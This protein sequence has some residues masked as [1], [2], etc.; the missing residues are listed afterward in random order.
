MLLLVQDTKFETNQNALSLPNDFV[1]KNKG[2]VNVYCY[3]I[4]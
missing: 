1:T 2:L 3:F 4:K